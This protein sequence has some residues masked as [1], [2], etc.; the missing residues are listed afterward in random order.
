MRIFKTMIVV[1]MLVCL[2]AVSVFAANLEDVLDMRVKIDGDVIQENELNRVQFERGDIVDVEV[3]LVSDVDLDDVEVLAMVSGYEFNNLEPMS[4][5]SNIFDME[6]NVS[7]KKRLSIRVPIEVE[8]DDYKLR[9]IVS[10][11]Y[12][13]SAT[14]DFNLK[15]DSPR[16]G[17]QIEDVVFS[18]GNVV[19]AGRVLLTTVRVENKGERDEDSVKV[20]V[21][22][23]E[24]GLSASDFIDEV[25]YEDSETS[26][27]MYMRI[28]AC[29]APGDYKAVIEVK[30]NELREAIYD[31]AIITV[32]EGD[33]C[34]MQAAE[35]EKET[36]SEPGK[37]V[38][39]LGATSQ[40]LMKGKAGALYPLT[41]TNNGESTK[42][43][44]VTVE[45]TNDFASL[46]INP[47]STFVL[48]KGDSQAVFIYLTPLDDAAEGQR[49][50]TVSVTS[51]DEVL[52]Q[53]PLT[54]V[55]TE[56]ED[57]EGSE[58]MNLRSA[59]E[60][61][62]IVLVVILVILGII[63]GISKV[64]K[65]DDFEDDEEVD[66]KKTYY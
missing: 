53:I 11:R 5:T 61:A 20:T 65:D 49:I 18:P 42:A 33:V 4:D 21:A 7:Y 26:E 27:E 41:I 14:Y 47:V 60:I 29:A 62:L 37:T 9:V 13:G 28:P 35:K 48:N 51:G 36:A 24:L 22:I 38:I 30:Y 58:P 1:L 31:N 45:G 55:V 57:G 39:A 32:V 54:A 16:H 52:K 15:L 40:E 64:K 3:R 44:T 34:E 46:Q 10:D 59:L 50:F 8:E 63:V 2:S 43:Y 6:A 25:E 23:P 66:D 12:S 56:A 19:E 17:F